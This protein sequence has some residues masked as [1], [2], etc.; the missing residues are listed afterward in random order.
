MSSGMRDEGWLR[1]CPWWS[2]SNG[3]SIRVFV[4]K[5]KIQVGLHL[6]GLI[7]CQANN[8]RYG[9]RFPCVNAFASG[10]WLI[11]RPIPV[12]PTTASIIALHCQG[13][14]FQSYSRPI[15]EC[16]LCN[17]TSGRLWLLSLPVCLS[18]LA[19]FAQTQNWN[20]RTGKS[21]ATR[22]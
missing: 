3:W 6:A 17:R 21:I 4:E 14:S 8:G 10:I 11:D 2:E 9:H 5:S 1:G 19:S 16:I 7:G 12:Q 22:R 15:E 20:R 13:S 18:L